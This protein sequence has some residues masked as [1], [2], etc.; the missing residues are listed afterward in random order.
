MTGSIKGC[1][2]L[3]GGNYE[4]LRSYMLDL[5]VPSGIPADN[6]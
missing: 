5:D 3:I 2:A 6:P 1:E 4:R